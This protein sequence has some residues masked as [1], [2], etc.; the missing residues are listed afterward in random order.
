MCKER[1][2]GEAGKTVAGCELGCGTSDGGQPLGVIFLALE[3]REE[4]GS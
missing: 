4:N 3:K 1:R 2:E